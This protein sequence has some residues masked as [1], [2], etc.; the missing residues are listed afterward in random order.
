MLPAIP[1]IFH[2]RESELN[3]IV[4]TLHQGSARI[5]ILGAGGMGKTSLAK[6]ALHHPDIVTK[7]EQCFFVVSEAATTSIQL[8]ALIGEHI[9]LNPVKDLTQKV[10]N[11][12]SRRGPSLLVLDSLETVWEPLESRG[13]VEELLS[14]LTDVPHLALLVRWH[15]FKLRYS[16]TYHR[17]QCEEQNDQQKCAGHTRS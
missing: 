12:F 1:K 8:A 17:S 11:Y 7:Y 3:A 13:E 6:A 5:A 9:G 14:K 2:G 10:I 15:L 16:L 4:Q